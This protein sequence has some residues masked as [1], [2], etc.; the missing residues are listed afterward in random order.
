MKPEFTLAF[1]RF[2][3]EVA[4]LVAELTD[5]ELDSQYQPSSV[6]ADMEADERAVRP[7]VAAALTVEMRRR[8]IQG[9][10]NV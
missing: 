5:E 2:R 3:R 1:N 4:R 6:L 8:G 9:G 10:R 7:F